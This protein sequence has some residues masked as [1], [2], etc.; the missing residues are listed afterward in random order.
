MTLRI[1]TKKT[2]L[3]LLLLMPLI[4]FALTSLAQNAPPRNSALDEPLGNITTIGAMANAIFQLGI[5]A[6]IL[7]ACIYIAIGAFNYFVAAGGNAKRAE[8]GKAII[9]RAI[10]GL[11]LALVS[12]LILTTI[13]PQFTELKINASQESGGQ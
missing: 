4:G 11:I 3:V 5:A 7:A 9:Q 1:L 12:W 10:M 2:L 8:E 13:H 6:C